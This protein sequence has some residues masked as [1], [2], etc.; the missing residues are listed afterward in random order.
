MR[1]DCSSAVAHDLA[2]LRT[3]LA[4]MPT[5]PED[6]ERR[7]RWRPLLDIALDWSI[8]LLACLAVL[9]LGA[10]A[11]PVALLVIGWR[12]RA[13][14]NLLHEAGHGNLHPS[15]RVNDWLARLALAWPGCTD[16]SRYRVDH[17]EH[18]RQLGDRQRDPDLL[19]RRGQ[20]GW[21]AHLAEFTLDL[22]L[23]WSAASGDLFARRTGQRARVAILAWW[24]GAA[25]LATLS[26]GE[27]FAAAFVALW[28][29]A[30]ATTFHVLTMF[31]EMCDHFAMEPDSI[32]G[33]TREC[34]GRGPLAWLIHPHN[35]GYHL[36]HHL[37]PSVPYYNLPRAQH[38]LA[39]LP[40]YR[41]HGHVYSTYLFG[42]DSIVASMG[43]GARA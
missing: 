18:H 4:G 34:V 21:L 27:G 2:L 31:R 40:M 15:R 30:R 24:A 22:R 11:V 5:G 19:P 26:V 20:H 14:G 38:L 32:V 3:Q 1:K 28:F 35:N 25:G 7:G 13:L 39:Q 33:F 41:H 37:L 9:E 23:W 42:R 16:L 10:W 8:V 36:T 29:A 12:Q 17:Y 43:A 6:L